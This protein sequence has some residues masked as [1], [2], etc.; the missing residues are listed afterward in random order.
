MQLKK[1]IF[2]V[3]KPNKTYYYAYMV[4]LKTKKDL[5]LARKFFHILTGMMAM[6]V[7]YYFSFTGKQAA[8][9]AGGIGILG[10]LNELL[11]FK[12][13]KMNQ[14]FLFIVKPFARQE[15]TH[16]FSG[17]TY[18][19]FGVA[20]CFYFYPWP[21][22]NLAIYY[23][24]FA[25]PIASL[26]GQIW[27]QKKIIK[28]K[29]IIGSLAFATI[30]FFINIIYLNINDSPLLNNFLFLI[31]SPLVGAISEF[32]VIKDDNLSIPLI[33]GLGLYLLSLI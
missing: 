10:L 19:C 5:H 27:G 18:Y 12:F 31:L 7:T 25:D 8:F 1:K 22:A 20:L 30:C 15:E 23:L 24:I 26:C 14:I 21:I 6:G 3:L 29:S 13:S 2:N 28:N 32:L 11:R 4:E 16:S 17:L 33:S 9:V